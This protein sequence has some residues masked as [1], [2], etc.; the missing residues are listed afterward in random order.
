MNIL[1]FVMTVL[2][3]LSV[4]T[5]ARIDSTRNFMGMRSQF[6]H[7]MQLTERQYINE[8]NIDKYNQTKVSSRSNGKS[9]PGTGKISIKIL[10]DEDESESNPEQYLFIKNTVQSLAKELFS[11]EKFYKE[12]EKERPQ[13]LDELFTGLLKKGAKVPSTQPFKHAADLASIDLDD[14]LLQK[15]LYELL[16]ER[17]PNSESKKE[18]SLLNFVTMDTKGDSKIRLQLAPTPLLRV[19]F[20]G[21]QS[22]VDDVLEQRYQLFYQLNND[23]I[24]S[25][26]AKKTF[27]GLFKDRLSNKNF[28]E[29]IDFTLT[30]TNPKKYN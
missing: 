12:A 28:Q 18:F 3:L 2:M 16:R 6:E 25:E 11:E 7:Y 9:T 1:L 19:L 4:L 13:F 30:K 21:D 15:V 29:L 10:V 27:E 5:Y 17:P 22:T 24:S 26:E 8:K 20:N 14:D 23:K